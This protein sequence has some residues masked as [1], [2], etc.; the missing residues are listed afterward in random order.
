[1]LAR[2]SPGNL[3]V[4]SS[5]H[6]FWHTKNG[7]AVIGLVVLTVIGAIVGGAIG[8][9]RAHANMKRQ[10]IVSSSSPASATTSCS[11]SSSV[12]GAL[13]STS[14]YHSAIIV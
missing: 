4:T 12:A 14:T 8:G 2:N 5:L 10:I 9:V 11:C 1:M 13:F 6:P 7:L 3:A